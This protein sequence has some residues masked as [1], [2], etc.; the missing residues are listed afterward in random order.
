MFFF[1]LFVYKISET[2][3]FIVYFD[4]VKLVIRL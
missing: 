4:E 1:F 2:G 3:I